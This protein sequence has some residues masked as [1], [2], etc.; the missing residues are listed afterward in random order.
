MTA[1]AP[2]R[3]TE[4][5]PAGYE[6]RFDL[7]GW[8]LMHAL[9]RHKGGLRSRTP[10]L[11]DLGMGRGRDLI[12]FAGH[13][14]RALGVDLAA[15]GLVK[16]EKRAARF[17]LPIRTRLAD[18]RTF[19][20]PRRFDVVYSS[21]TLNHLPP[22]IRRA[23][24]EHFKTSTV[25][26]GLHAVNA[27][28]LPPGARALPDLDPGLWPFRPGELLGHYRDWEVLEAG[29]QEIDCRLGGGPGHRHLYEFVVSRRPGVTLEARAKGRPSRRG[30][31]HPAAVSSVCAVRGHADRVGR[32][33]YAYGTTMSR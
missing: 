19:R 17:N 11:I 6:G 12:F 8:E 22:S 15:S 1:R 4:R 26:G 27:F 3:A 2:V 16:A 9:Y 18:L 20:F 5:A 21:S 29:R 25:P 31:V 14:F 13:G 23:R 33:P 10:S 32:T 7:A 28:L 24:F 30:G